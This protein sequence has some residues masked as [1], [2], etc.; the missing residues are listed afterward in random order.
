MLAKLLDEEIARSHPSESSGTSTQDGPQDGEEKCVHPQGCLP[1]DE[2]RRQERVRQRGQEIPPV[3]GDIPRQK[4]VENPLRGPDPEVQ[5]Q[6]PKGGSQ[7]QVDGG[8]GRSAAF[9]GVSLQNRLLAR[10]WLARGDL[11]DL[12]PACPA[13]IPGSLAG[14]RIISSHSRGVPTW[15]RST[16]PRWP[17]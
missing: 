7:E 4:I 2:E 12:S 8:A 10:D 17:A 14:G 1:A 16:K 6:T 13:I 5:E 3:P 9:I 15:Q 11:S